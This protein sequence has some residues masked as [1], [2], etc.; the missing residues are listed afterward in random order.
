MP[1]N[2]RTVIPIGVVCYCIYLELLFP[3]CTCIIVCMPRMADAC[4]CNEFLMMLLILLLYDIE[5]GDY[6][7]IVQIKGRGATYG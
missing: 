7:I 4:M 1:R 3:I 6:I 2:T 5:P